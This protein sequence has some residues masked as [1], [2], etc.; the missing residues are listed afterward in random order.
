M[1]P[2]QA[3]RLKTLSFG[4][5]IR[6]VVRIQEMP[7]EELKDVTNR[8]LSESSKY[9]HQSSD[10]DVFYISELKIAVKEANPR[11]LIITGIESKSPLYGKGIKEGDII[12]EADRTDIFSADNL[13]DNIRNAIIDDFRPIS[14]LIQGIDNTFYSTIE[15]APE[16]D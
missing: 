11:G 10:K 16:N 13:L 3:L 8:A 2:G 9:Y 5:E 1:E 6:N 14:L 4:E 15:L 12:L 7:A